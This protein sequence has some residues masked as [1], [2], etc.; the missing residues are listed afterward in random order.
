MHR[1]RRMGLKCM[2]IYASLMLQH[3]RVI[4][5]TRTGTTQNSALPIYFDLLWYFTTYSQCQIPHSHHFSTLFWRQAR[6]VFTSIIYI[7]TSCPRICLTQCDVQCY[8]LTQWRLP[9]FRVSWLL[10]MWRQN[11]FLD[12]RCSIPFYLIMIPSRAFLVLGVPVW[13]PQTIF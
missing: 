11:S 5:Q 2:E 8:I 10:M 7:T 4:A 3:G 13:S 6:I 9:T 12:W 1:L